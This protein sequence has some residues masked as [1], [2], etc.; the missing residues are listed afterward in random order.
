MTQLTETARTALAEIASRHGASQEAVEHLLMALVAGQGTQAQFNHPDLGGMGQWSQGGM[1][2][3][4]DMFNNGLKAKVDLLCSELAKLMRQSDLLDQPNQAA[5]Q[6]QTQGDATSLFVEGGAPGNWWPTG[7]G[8]AASTGAQNRMRYAW[9]P[10]TARLAIDTGNGRVRVY[11]TADHRIGGFSQQ[12]SGDQSL[13]FTS[14]HGLVKIA[15]LREVE[16]SDVADT[17]QEPVASESSA[18]PG[19]PALSD[20]LFKVAS[21]NRTEQAGQVRTDPAPQLPD[22]DQT[23]QTGKSAE[24]ADEADIFAKIE[25]LAALHARAILTDDEYQAKKAELLARI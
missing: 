15:D 19:A 16:T 13:S 25:R 21:G 7:L 1:T 20:V 5:T 24:T 14:Q 2:M 12:Q 22:T 10:D 8:H 9:F 3:V 11:D 6:S 17:G 4:G 23:A 18:R